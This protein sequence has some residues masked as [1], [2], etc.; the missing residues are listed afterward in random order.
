MI[1]KQLYFL[2]NCRLGLSVTKIYEPFGLN[3]LIY[4]GITD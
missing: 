2:L 4:N 1:Y 3:I